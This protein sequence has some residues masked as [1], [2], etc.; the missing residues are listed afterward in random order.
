[1]HRNPAL[2]LFALL[3]A[4]AT[5][6]QAASLTLPFG[7]QDR[8]ALVREGGA[9]LGLALMQRWTH[10]DEAPRVSLWMPRSNYPGAMGLRAT[11]NLR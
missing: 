8:G 7:L 3:I 9:R 5:P 2:P 6:L 4:L 10:V 1:M 11:W